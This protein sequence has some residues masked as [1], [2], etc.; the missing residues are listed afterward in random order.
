MH[1]DHDAAVKTVEKLQQLNKEDNVFVCLAHD[2]YLTPV[3]DT[4][5]AL[6]NRWRANSW[7][8]SAK[9]TVEQG[10]G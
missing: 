7:K 9:Q 10:A 5:P 3:I 2:E 6:L 4:F 8:T 1:K